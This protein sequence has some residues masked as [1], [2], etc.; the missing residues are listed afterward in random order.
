MSPEEDIRAALEG[1]LAAL[2][3]GL[4]EVLMLAGPPPS[5]AQELAM[6][7][8]VERTASVALLK[9]VEQL[10]DILMR[11]FRTLLRLDGVDTSELT[12]RDIANRMEKW[13]L[14]ASADD[15]MAIVRLRNRLAH[16]YPVNPAEQLDRLLQ[17]YRAAEG[18][19][20]TAARVVDHLAARPRT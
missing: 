3:A 17:A 20:I 7:S 13:A 10:E 11:L 16:E 6:R 15:W 5:S 8:A 18:L 19:K 4:D 9:R 1:R 14:L 2:L 12:N